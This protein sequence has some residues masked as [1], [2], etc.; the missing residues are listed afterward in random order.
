MLLLCSADMP[1]RAIIANMKLFNGKHG[2]STCE[3]PGDNKSG[4]SS[5]NR[6]WPFQEVNVVRTKQMAY[7]AITKTTEQ[8]QAVC[9]CMHVCT[10]V[11][12]IDS[13]VT[14]LTVD[15]SDF[16]ALTVDFAIVYG[17]MPIDSTP[18]GRIP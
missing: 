8:K 1:A 12:I 10:Y 5:L 2:C 11:Y 7:T 18:S 16:Q 6:L 4:S 13:A 17:R 9:S 15:H 14:T 3:D